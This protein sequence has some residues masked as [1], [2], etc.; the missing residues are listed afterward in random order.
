LPLLP[1]YKLWNVQFLINFFVPLEEKKV[2]I[3]CIQD[4][5]EVVMN[6]ARR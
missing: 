1:F 5:P 4:E 2:F 3:V 6:Y